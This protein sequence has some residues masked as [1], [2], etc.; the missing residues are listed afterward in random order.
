MA[1]SN[2]KAL[3]HKHLYLAAITTV[4]MT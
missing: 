3:K 4:A 2:N 1:I